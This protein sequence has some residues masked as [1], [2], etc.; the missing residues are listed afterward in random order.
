MSAAVPNRVLDALLERLYASLARG[1]ALNANPGNSRQRLD[2]AQIEKLGASASTVLIDVLGEAKSHKIR[3]ALVAPPKVEKADEAEGDKR[4]RREYD[5]AQKLLRKFSSIAKEADTYQR[6]TGSAAQFIG[7]PLL[8]L[9]EAASRGRIGTSRLLA[10]LC[11]LPVSLEVVTG[12]RASVTI[13]SSATTG[14]DRVIANVALKTWIERQAGAKYPALFEDEEGADPFGE[15]SELLAHVAEALGIKNPPS[16]EGWP[17]ERVPDAKGLGDLAMFLPSAVLG[18]FPIAKQGAIRDLEDVKAREV[19]PETVRPFVTLD[20]S[21]TTTSDVVYSSKDGAAVDLLPSQ[22]EHLVDWADPCQ[23]RAVIRARTTRGLVV[24]GPP[25]TGK[26]QTITNIIGDYLAR[27]KRVLLVCEKRTALDVVKYRL[28]ARDLGHLCAVVHDATSDRTT[29][30]TGIREQLDAL[31]DSPLRPDPQHDLDRANK[32]IDAIN[33]EL[34]EYYARFQEV[35]AETGRNFHELMGLWFATAEESAFAPIELDPELKSVSPNTIRE[36]EGILR[37]AYRR[38]IESSLADNGWDGNHRLTLETFLG[39]R[40]DEMRR[41]M[42]ECVR[43]SR[44]S[45]SKATPSLPPFTPT[46]PLDE[47]AKWREEAAAELR[48]IASQATSVFRETACKLNADIIADS[49]RSLDSLEAQRN[50]LANT[51]LAPDLWQLYSAAPWPVPQ[52]ASGVATLTNYLEK[53]QG[54]FGFFQFA[55]K[56]EAGGVLSS[57]ALALNRPNAEKAKQFLEG[58]HARNILRAWLVERMPEGFAPDRLDAGLSRQITDFRRCIALLADAD[59]RPGYAPFAEHFRKELPEGSA[60]LADLLTRSTQAAQAIQD[61]IAAIQSSNIFSDTAVTALREKLLFGRAIDGDMEKLREDLERLE[62]LLRFQA[63]VAPFPPAVGHALKQLA[64]NDQPEELAWRRLLAGAFA[65]QLERIVQQNPILQRCD[66]ARID[67]NFKRLRELTGQ[68]AA[69]EARMIQF[70]WQ[71]HQ[72]ERLLA[73]TGSRLSSNGA[74]LRRRLMLR[75]K[76]ASRIRQVIHDGLTMA[77]GDPLFDIHPVWM[78]SPETA[79]TIFPPDR[80]FDVVIFDEASQCRLEEGLPVL[81]RGEN[82]VIAGDTKQLPPTRFFESAIVSSD[83]TEDDD[84]GSEG[85]F[86]SQQSDIEDLLSASLNIE[87]EQAYLDVHYRSQNEDLIRFSNEAFYG[88]R[89]QAIPAHPNAGFS[90]SSPVVLNQVHGTCENRQNQIE[91]HF[92][93]ERV[94]EILASPD[95][96][97]IGIVS[98]NLTQKDLIEEA[99]DAAAEEDPSFRAKLSEARVRE[100]RGAFEGLFVKNLENVQG[101]ERDVIIL[102]T[103]Y[104]PNAEGKFYRRFGP[105]GTAGG[106]RRL[107][108]IITRARLR[109]EVVTSIPSSV[110]RA[111]AN[112]S[113]PAGKRPNGAWFLMRYLRQAELLE[114]LYAKVGEQ[115]PGELLESAGLA[116]NDCIVNESGVPSMF[117]ETFA[118]LLMEKHGVASVLYH[119]NDGF[120]VDLAFR[121]P[122]RPDNVTIGVLFDGTRYPRAQDRVEWDG[123]KTV[124]LESQ[125]WELHRIWTPQFLRDPAAAVRQ[126]LAAS[127]RFVAREETERKLAQ[128]DA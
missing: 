28:E 128:E 71:K 23:R 127:A 86:Q 78:T 15:V 98:F 19:M 40:M 37:A 8:S 59:Q 42:D 53:V 20:A 74:D 114:E 118:R 52:V 107:N 38:L 121:H 32:E 91:A 94:R 84:L 34:Q 5:D 56:K 66:A 16:L 3:P 89:L 57:F 31:A 49:I 6:D 30:Y 35:D 100:S 51:P 27:K 14:G 126:L 116:P 117:V 69:Y 1:P 105:L 122:E 120:Y 63:E 13:Q 64:S 82:V 12:S 76:Q 73:S 95:A 79:S 101:D 50:L 108:V 44:E 47:Q 123:F 68:K 125:K 11:F 109:V 60:A 17:V 104:G 25:G 55:A 2:L 72:R 21:L 43:L 41:T 4:A 99:L 93:V 77:G 111:D 26:S 85:L 58:V 96:P 24:H 18:L 62:P 83:S 81:L 33:A 92:V 54:I 110:Y 70:I 22:E 29:L 102:S 65:G 61:T 45:S 90:K 119:G 48:Q 9:P 115:P 67:G 103:T 7:Y 10:P 39:R 80:I 124:V 106:E 88:S 46:I 36:S 113:P 112:I 97:S 87:V 75:G